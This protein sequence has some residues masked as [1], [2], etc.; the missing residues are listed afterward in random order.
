MSYKIHITS[1]VECGTAVQCHPRSQL[2]G[3]TKLSIRN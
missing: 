3:Y 2:K 1:A